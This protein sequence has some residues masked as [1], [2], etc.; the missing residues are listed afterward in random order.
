LR[1]EL[2]NPL[3]VGYEAHLHGGALAGQICDALH[4]EGLVLASTDEVAVPPVA[5]P[6]MSA[7]EESNIQA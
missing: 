6:A 7:C 3:L 4:G 1:I 2:I 5:T